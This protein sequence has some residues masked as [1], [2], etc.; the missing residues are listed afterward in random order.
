M[1]NP[2]CWGKM[3]CVTPINYYNKTN[4]IKQRLQFWS[5]CSKLE[6]CKKLGK[7]KKRIVNL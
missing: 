4:I 2:L 7:K 5:L 3:Y 6:V 1:K